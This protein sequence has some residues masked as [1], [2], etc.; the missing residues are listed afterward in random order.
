[1]KKKNLG[2][3]PRKKKIQQLTIA[4]LYHALSE[5]EKKT[6]FSKDHEIIDKDTL[7]TV[8]Y[9]KQILKARGYRIQDIRITGHDISALQKI[10]ADYIFNLA[11]SKAMEI[12]IAGILERL[13]I[14]YSGSG[15]EAIRI[16][17]N[18][19][20]SKSIF[21]KFRIPTPASVVLYPGDKI[22]RSILP[23]KFPLIVKPAFDHGS[24]GITDKS[25]ITTFKQL[26]KTVKDMRRKNKQALICEQFIKGK[27]I[28]ILILERRGETVALP[29]AEMISRGKKKSKWNIYGF[30]EKWMKKS[31]AFRN[32]TF[33]APPKGIPE[34]VLHL[35]RRDAIRAFYT[36]GFKDYGR[37]DMRYSPKTKQWYFLEGNANSG[38]TSHPDDASTVSIGSFGLTLEEF[39][40]NIVH[41]S[42]PETDKTGGNVR[43]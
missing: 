28:Q 18:K 41:N 11:D 43:A 24:I 9:F 42:L 8:K 5:D 36:M 1:V 15:S 17:N 14:P 19:I 25:V 2:T 12:Q 22:T 35:M 10:K 26:Q 13:H 30:E 33:R 23:G 27:E 21:D 40:L 29:P 3:K 39:I 31:A 20:R 38:L 7:K 34:T 4:L 6:Y 16:S 37:F 32:C